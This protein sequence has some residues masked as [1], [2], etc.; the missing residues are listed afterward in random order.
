MVQF[1]VLRLE[2]DLVRF[3]GSLCYSALLPPGDTRRCWEMISVGIAK[4]NTPQDRFSCC[5]YSSVA[6]RLLLDFFHV[7]IVYQGQHA[8]L[9]DR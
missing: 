6:P 8:W 2:E 4:A 7:V 3:V 5:Q 1:L 9:G